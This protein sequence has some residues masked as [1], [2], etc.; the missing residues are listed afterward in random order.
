VGDKFDCCF[1][2]CGVPSALDLCIKA[3]TSGGTVCVVANFTE[4]VP[5]RLQEAAR[6]EIDII[7]VYRYCNLYPRALAL[8]ASGKVDLKPL[9]SK[10][11]ALA[12]VNEAFEYFASGEPVKVIIQPNA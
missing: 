8:V 1:E 2:C 3:A 12:E 4:S 6:R 7:G 11:F 10:R 5:V 9:V